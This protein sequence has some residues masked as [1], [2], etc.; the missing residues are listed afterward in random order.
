[1]FFSLGKFAT[2]RS[3]ISALKTGPGCLSL[4]VLFFFPIKMT[5]VFQFPARDARNA[6]IPFEA[7]KSP[8]GQP[9]YPL[10]LA[11]ATPYYNSKFQKVK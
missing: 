1:M 11:H 8:K 2:R 5:E 3:P 4:P 7:F 6:S 10:L 9:F